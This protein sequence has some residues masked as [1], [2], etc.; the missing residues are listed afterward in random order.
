FADIRVEWMKARARADRWREELTLVDEEMRRV[1]AF[2][3]WKANWWE[4]RLVPVR[5]G[6]RGEISPALA[7]GLRAYAL[8]QV[9]RERKWESAWRRKWAA[10]RARAGL[11]L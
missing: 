10:V 5:D 6:G 2:C 4:A 11:V 8:A 9:A 7:E 3:A 1:L